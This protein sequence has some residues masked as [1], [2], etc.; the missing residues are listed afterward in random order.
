MVDGFVGLPEL[1]HPD[2]LTMP[3]LGTAQGWGRWTWQLGRQPGTLAGDGDTASAH[4][5]FED[6]SGNQTLVRMP[7][8]APL[9]PTP[10]ML[11]VEILANPAGDEGQQ[12]FVELQNVGAEPVD[13]AGFALSDGKGQ[14]VLPAKTVAPGQRVLVV[15]ETFDALGTKTRLQLQACRLSVSRAPRGDGPANGEK[16]FHC[17]MPG[18]VSRYS[19][20]HDVSDDR[21]NGRSVVR[22]FRR[23]QTWL[24]PPRPAPGLVT[25]KLFLLK[26]RRCQRLGEDGLGVCSA[27]ERLG[28]TT[29][30]GGQVH[31][32]FSECGRHVPCPATTVGPR[33]NTKEATASKKSKMWTK[34]IKEITVSARWVVGTPV[35][36]PV[37]AGH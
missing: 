26:P 13:L 8:P 19:G 21:W 23:R 31:L 37:C 36:T 17:W 3:L 34:Y 22:V 28:P 10:A 9:G 30:R 18:P 11:I 12:E 32:N 16:R 33:S 5:R 7:V 29:S 15:P 1:G 35:A 24:A 27:R 4:V 14:D 25:R 20:W 6:A 2:P